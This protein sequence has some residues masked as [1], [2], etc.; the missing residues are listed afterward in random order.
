MDGGSSEPKVEGLE[1]GRGA[2]SHH[3]YSQT[4]MKSL[5]EQ[6]NSVFI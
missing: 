2:D 6:N 4:G 5:D 3:S 1:V